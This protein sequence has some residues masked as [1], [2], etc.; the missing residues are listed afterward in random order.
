M[1]PVRAVHH[2][3]YTVGDLGRSLAFYRDLLGMEEIAVQ[4]KQGGYLAAI[5]G[6]PDAHVRMA[7]LRMPGGEH[8]LELFEYLAPTGTKAT[9]IQPKDAGAQHLCFAVEDLPGLYEDL[10]AAGVDTFLSP[11]VAVDTG[12]NRGGFAL[13]LRDPDGI[14]VELFQPPVRPEVEA[15]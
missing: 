2:T 8:M 10:V 3:G 5:V 12:V 15:A 1:S 13:Y 14:P 6:Y 11:P 9:D 7:H 4:E